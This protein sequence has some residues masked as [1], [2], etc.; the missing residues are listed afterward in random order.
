VG[1]AGQSEIP[2]NVGMME[3]WNVGM[4]E[5]QRISELANQPTGWQVSGFWDFMVR[6]LEFGN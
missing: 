5:S 6:S 2:W 1:T 3:D 4:M